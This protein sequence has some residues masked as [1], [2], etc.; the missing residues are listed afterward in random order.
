MDAIYEAPYLKR[1]EY[2]VPLDEQSEILRSLAA[3][4]DIEGE[5]LKRYIALSDLT[6]TAGSPVA[7]IAERF[8]DL[9]SLKNF[10]IIKTPEVISPKVVFDLL[11]FRRTTRHAVRATVIMWIKITSCVRTR[12]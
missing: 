9:P 11:I 12:V 7:A 5:R 2:D 10:D 6:R 1:K 4:T 3:R 8:I